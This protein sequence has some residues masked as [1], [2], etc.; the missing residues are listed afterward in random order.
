[1]VIMFIVLVLF[2]VDRLV[3][4][5][6]NLVIR[7][8][9]RIQNLLRL[10]EWMRLIADEHPGMMD[11]DIRTGATVLVFSLLWIGRD[12]DYVFRKGTKWEPGQLFF[13]VPLV[14]Y[15]AITWVVLLRA[16][17]RLCR[18]VSPDTPLVEYE[19]Y[20]KEQTILELDPSEGDGGWEGQLERF[21]DR[22]K[23]TCL[24]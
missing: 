20:E 24:P 19:G 8:G 14:V 10:P 17:R 11:K 23:R 6:R 15:A 21:S 1:M 3:V 7:L 2:S 9:R 22:R 13:V 12:V 4:R 5:R 16:K 18:R